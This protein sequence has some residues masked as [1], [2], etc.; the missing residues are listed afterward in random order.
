MFYHQNPITSF[1]LE[2]YCSLGMKGSIDEE[3]QK[4]LQEAQDEGELQEID[5]NESEI[6]V[7]DK[8]GNKVQVKG[9][10]EKGKVTKKG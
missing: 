8:D 6:T 7:T 1:L 5:L 2:F 4:A 10:V 3:Y 9:D